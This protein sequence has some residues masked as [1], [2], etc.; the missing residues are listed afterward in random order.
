M[1]EETSI[2]CASIDCV[3]LKWPRELDNGYKTLRSSRQ[4]RREAS[5]RTV[6]TPRV[7]TCLWVCGQKFIPYGTM[8]QCCMHSGFWV[9]ILPIGICSIGSNLAYLRAHDFNT[10]DKVG[11]CSPGSYIYT[12]LFHVKQQI[13]GQTTIC[14]GH[15]RQSHV[16]DISIA[17]WLMV[18]QG[19]LSLF[20]ASQ[21][22]PDT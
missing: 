22:N 3:I 5:K 9:R 19:C 21:A 20:E 6:V 4:F 14:V 17:T 10:R 11:W 18:S 1:F 8:V 12:A 15:D 16:Q 2:K 13:R 7:M